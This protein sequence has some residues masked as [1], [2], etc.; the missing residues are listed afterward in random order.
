MFNLSHY[1]ISDNNAAKSVCLE[2][3]IK[4]EYSV[5]N[6]IFFENFDNVVKGRLALPK[7][8]NV[9][10]CYLHKSVSWESFQSNGGPQWN[11][12][13]WDYYNCNIKVSHSCNCLVFQIFILW[14]TIG[15]FEYK[16]ERL[17]KHKKMSIS[18]FWGHVGIKKF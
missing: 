17:Q 5:D 15:L 1:L 14:C 4:S 9:A 8:T 13:L 16:N 11:Y 12:G 10:P 18:S 6:I 7:W 3:L 2:I